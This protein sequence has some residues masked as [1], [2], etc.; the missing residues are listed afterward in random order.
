MHRHTPYWASS[1]NPSSR[2]HRWPQAISINLWPYDLRHKNNVKNSISDSS[3]GSSPTTRFSQVHLSPTVRLYHTFECPI[4]SLNTNL[5]N[6]NSIPKC[7]PRS[8]LGAYIGKSP[9]HAQ[10]VS[11]VLSTITGIT[12]PQFHITH[13]DFFETRKKFQRNQ[14]PV[15]WD[16]DDVRPV[17]VLSTNE[18]DWACRDDLPM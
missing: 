8:T 1:Q 14:A 10:S 12:S 11:L 5:Q 17:V 18:T 6:N 4:F 16:C 7:S 3:D 13:D 9:R 2:Y 15:K